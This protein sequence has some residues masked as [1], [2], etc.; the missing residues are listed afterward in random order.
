MAKVKA[1]QL[2]GNVEVNPTA[3]EAA[4]GSKQGFWD[5][6]DLSLFDVGDGRSRQPSR[7]DV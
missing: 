2:T 1:E 5:K 7:Q 3:G 4:Y 6:L